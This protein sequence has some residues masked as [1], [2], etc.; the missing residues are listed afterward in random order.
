MQDL[1]VRMLDES[2]DFPPIEALIAEHNRTVEALCDA[3]RR[4]T[5]E[6]Q[7]EWLAAYPQWRPRPRK[8]DAR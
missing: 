6:Q 4:L 2:G 8:D 5:P 7:T 1:A 3:V